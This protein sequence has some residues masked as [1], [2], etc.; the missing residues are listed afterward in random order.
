MSRSDNID[1]MVCK[2]CQHTT[3]LDSPVNSDGQPI[4]DWFCSRCDQ[5]LF[6]V[7]FIKPPHPDT[8]SI[9]CKFCS[10]RTNLVFSED[11]AAKRVVKW[12]CIKC[13]NQLVKLHVKTQETGKNKNLW[14]QTRS[15]NSSQTK[16]TNP[17][18]D[19][20]G[21]FIRKHWKILGV[22]AVCLFVWVKLNDGASQNFSINSG[23]SSASS[24][25]NVYRGT[26]IA[27]EE[28]IKYSK[29]ER[30]RIQKFL[31]DN[32]G[33][34]STIDGLWGAKTAESFLRAANRY[35]KGKS[36]YS[37]SNVNSVF[38]TVLNKQK[39]IPNSKTTQTINRSTN[40]GGLS[41]SAIYQR[42]YGV[43]MANCFGKSP[44]CLA[45]VQIKYLLIAKDAAC[46]REFGRPCK[47]NI[48]ID[49]DWDYFPANGQWR[50]RGIHTGQFANNS[51]CRYDFKDDDRWPG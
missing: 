15:Q 22:A 46:R 38:Q 51:K 30:V 3:L 12:N 39:N 2:S 42:M 16:Q 11:G 27:R 5:K 4:Q 47:Y 24:N 10:Q 37:P 13:S 8:V 32:F 41:L 31:K 7:S 48:D 23:N 6:S 40:N 26:K 33:Y 43:E 44:D 18:P 29:S 9:I 45:S 35:A 21:K 49:W 20:L 19:A 17:N 25:E 34:R 50:C 28:F 14:N 36:L 1:T